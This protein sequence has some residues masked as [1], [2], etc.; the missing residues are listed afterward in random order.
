MSKKRQRN[1]GSQ[2]FAQQI[3]KSQMTVPPGEDKFIRSIMPRDPLDIW[4][5]QFLSLE[6]EK[7]EDLQ[8]KWSNLRQGYLDGHTKKGSY[9]IS[10]Q[11]ILAGVGNNAQYVEM[12]HYYGIIDKKVN[13][14]EKRCK[15]IFA[16]VDE[17]DLGGKK[18]RKTKRK[19]LR[20][21]R[22][23]KRR[24]KSKRRKTR[25]KKRRGGD[26]YDEYPFL[27]GKKWKKKPTQRE[28]TEVNTSFAPWE[29][30]FKKP[31]YSEFD[32]KTWLDPEGRVISKPFGS[33]SW[34]TKENAQFMKE[35]EENEKIIKKKIEEKIKKQGENN[36]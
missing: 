9:A 3:Q 18:R 30:G 32:S 8:R 19:T 13:I 11:Y 28:P 26:E 12:E 7:Q 25:V 5:Q 31:D 10:M 17:L 27:D 29:P 4:R 34:P 35:Y 2:N 23:T 15:H 1:Q 16:P 14:L 20:N 21:K 36:F 22:K 24:N 33:R 6:K